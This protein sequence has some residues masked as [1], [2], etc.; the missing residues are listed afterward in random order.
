MLTFCKLPWCSRERVSDQCRWAPSWQLVG[1]VPMLRIQR[2]PTDLWHLNGSSPLPSRRQVRMP[3]HDNPPI[4]CPTPLTACSFLHRLKFLFTVCSFYTRPAFPKAAFL[5]PPHFA[6]SA[7]RSETGHPGFQWH[8]MR[9]E[10]LSF[11]SGRYEVS[12]LLSTDHPA[13]LFL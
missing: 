1:R 2:S 7:G 8:A 12:Q 3:W 11:F 6:V 10:A 9:R 5:R 4:F 13:A